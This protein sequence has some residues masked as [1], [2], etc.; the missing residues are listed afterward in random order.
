[1]TASALTRPLIRELV[2]R[3]C[4]RARGDA[5]LGPIFEAA[6]SDWEA[7]LE[8]LTAF[9]AASL[10]GERGFSGNPMA[11]HARHPITPEMFDRWLVL[12]GETAR[13]L[14]APEISEVL[15]ERAARI[16]ESLK[17]GLFFRV[18]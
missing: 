16:A 15:E 4:G 17:L 6:V 10:L 5:E 13:E 1:M 9:W 12:W 8:H 18:S 11:A 7:H 14:F 3:F 2:G